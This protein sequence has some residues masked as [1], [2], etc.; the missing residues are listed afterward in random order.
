M[1][2]LYVNTHFAPDYH[3]G[4]VVESSSKIFKYVGR[5]LHFYV[6]AVSKTP[7]QV[8][9]HIQSKGACY[10]SIIFHRFGFSLALVAPLWI[11]IRKHDGIV[12]NGI[13]TFPVTLAQIFSL[14]Q[15][16]PFVV[17]IRGGLEPWRL[18]QKRFR[19]LIFNT[20]ITFPLLRRA[21]CI[22]VTS[23]REY[24]NLMG[25][26]FK[27]I[28][29]IKNGIDCELIDSFT[30][31]YERFFDEKKFVFLF[32]SRTDKEKG[33]DL[34][35][36]AYERLIQEFG[37]GDLLLAIVGPDYSGYLDSL[38]ID[39]EARK[40]YRSEGI[41]GERKFQLIFESDCIVLPSY[42]ENFGNIVAEGMAMGRTV[43]TTTGTPW[44]V[45]ADLKIGFYI[46]PTS[47]DLFTAMRA[48]YLMSEQERTEVGHR[49]KMYV[50]N[51]ISWNQISEEFISFFYQVFQRG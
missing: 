43:I 40:I 31:K 6:V 46:T 25:L 17:S 22:H 10:K 50:Y 3:F 42:S 37:K 18:Q 34:L 27:R 2:L 51:N 14:L 12:I 44:K 4:G 39:F 8:N 45:L 5:K 7:Q 11:L 21:A 13:F 41:Y 9:A 1:K 23:D 35:V 33:I 28:Q 26:G 24:E 15:R 48:A 19:K 16:K 20:L 32:L 38:S 49:A 36:K 30:P 47:E 29:L